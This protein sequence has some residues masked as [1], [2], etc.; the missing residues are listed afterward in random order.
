M[1][2][3]RGIVMSKSSR[4]LP[5]RA[6]K[7]Q[8]APLKT[9]A[10]QTARVLPRQAKEPTKMEAVQTAKVLPQ[11][12]KEPAKTEAVQT[13]RVLLRQVKEPAKSEAVQ[14]VADSTQERRKSTRLRKRKTPDPDSSDDSNQVSG[15]RIC[16]KAKP[17]RRAVRSDK[18][19]PKQRGPITKMGRQIPL[20]FTARG[21]TLCKVVTQAE[22]SNVS[23]SKTTVAAEH[24]RHREDSN[25][26]M[27]EWLELKANK[28]DL[29]GLQWH[30]KSRKLVRIS[31]KHG[32]KS[33][34]TADDSQVFI[35]WARCTGQQ[36]TI[37]FIFIITLFLKS[38]L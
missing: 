17:P 27:R 4:V 19:I 1:M 9:E 38:D 2:Y 28:G 29:P 15:S 10:V 35:S 8:A 26:L 16:R 37:A 12:A 23:P 25:M 3:C 24:G 13:P 31:W 34:W 11:Q 6:A 14:A 5:R 7:E 20:T 21:K 36:S 32:S 33:G 30:D 18:W 22:S